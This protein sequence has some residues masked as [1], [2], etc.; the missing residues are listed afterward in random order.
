MDLH[1]LSEFAVNHLLLVAAFIGILAMLA[2]NE[3]RHHFGKVRDVTPTE[4]TRLINHE[5]AVL[6]DIRNDKDYR[7]GHVVNAVHV[8]AEKNEAVGKLEKYRDRPL[9]VCCRSGNQSRSLSAA[10]SKK[11]FAS[12]YNLKGGLHA[13]QQAG[14]PLSKTR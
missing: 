10:L 1:Q 8:T 9:I 3:L 4:A 14:L 11:G 2:G 13:W 6:V 12:V 5:N 7:D